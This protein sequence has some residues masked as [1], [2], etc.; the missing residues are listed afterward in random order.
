MIVI[1]QGCDGHPNADVAQVFGLRQLRQ[2]E[3]PQSDLAQRSDF[4]SAEESAGFGLEPRHSG[5]HPSRRADRPGTSCLDEPSRFYRP[6]RCAS[7]IPPPS[8][9]VLQASIDTPP[10]SPPSHR[11]SHSSDA[12]ISCSQVVYTLSP[13]SDTDIQRVPLGPRWHDYSFRES[14][15]YYC[16]PPR[17][18]N[19]ETAEPA[20]KS[21]S[22][23]SS[24]SR[25]W[26]RVTRT[27]RSSG[28]FQVTRAGGPSSG[29]V[30]A[31]MDTAGR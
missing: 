19:W 28:G 22:A 3:M 5:L 8:T 25:L 18:R 12:G 31:R 9:A 23:T 29:G 1:I 10:R 17:R 27:P 7:A 20:H 30:E 16:A 4:N 24:T 26:A 2:R 13:L 21:S 6:P 14:D 11:P 15:L